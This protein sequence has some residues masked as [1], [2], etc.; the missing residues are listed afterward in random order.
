[1][2]VKIVAL[3]LLPLLILG[4]RTSATPIVPRVGVMTESDGAL[5]L[6]MN[7]LP[8]PNISYESHAR[9]L[10]VL[11][12]RELPFLV[13]CDSSDCAFDCTAIKLDTLELG[14]CYSIDYG[15]GSGGIVVPSGESFDGAVLLG[16]DCPADAQIPA[17]NKCY[18]FVGHVF[19]LE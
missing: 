3:L 19:T 9:S 6:S 12:K 8:K 11:G 1:M 5:P 2:F 4:G 14:T 17:V 10:G 13:L 18:N 16:I 15:Y 7:L